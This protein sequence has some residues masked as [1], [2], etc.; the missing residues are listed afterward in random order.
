MCVAF[1]SVKRCDFCLVEV[2]ESNKVAD[3]DGFIYFQWCLSFFKSIDLANPKEVY[4]LAVNLYP[5]VCSIAF[6]CLSWRL[7]VPLVLGF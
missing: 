2:R 1:A 7:P 5:S 6:C 4:S 3:L